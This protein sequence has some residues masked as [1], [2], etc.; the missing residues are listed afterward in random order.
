MRQTVGFDRFNDLFETL[1]DGAEERFDTYPPYNIE[2]TGEDDYRIAIAVAGFSE[3]DLDI[4]AENDRLN[5]SGRVD[6]K[7]EGGDERTFLHKGIA[8]RAFQRT[9]R[10]A[11]HIKV[12]HAALENGMLIIDLKR[13]IPEEKKPR[14]IPINVVKKTLLG[15]KKN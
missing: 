6:D 13:E 2:K 8:T 10:L 4:T 12:E 3:N 7:T 14:M 9:F 1:L 5:V 11:D 15:K